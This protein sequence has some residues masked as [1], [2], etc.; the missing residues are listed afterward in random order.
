MEK[1]LQEIVD[2]LGNNI[3]NIEE[4]AQDP[5]EY[6]KALEELYELI[7]KGFEVKEYRTAPI[8]F[9]LF[10]RE[11]EDIHVLEFRHFITNMMFWEPLVVLDVYE[12]MD[13]SHIVNCNELS[14][15]VIK[16]YI[17][18]KIILP[19]RT[20]VGNR[21]LN[22][23]IHD[24]IYTLSR[25][26]KD[27]NII[28]G[29]S[30][31]VETF[32]DVA[33]KNPRFNEII[34]TQ[35][36]ENTQPH[37]IE[38]TLDRL[39]KEQI[40][41]L[42]TEDNFLKPILLSKTGIKDKQLSEFAI[43]G[44]LKPDIE[45]NT[46]PVPINSNFIVGGLKNI[47]NYY[48]DSLGGR[49]SA[50]MNATVMGS[51]G[52]FARMMMMLGTT[53]MMDKDNDDCGSV[54]PIKFTIKTK[55]HLKRLKGR[56]YRPLT[57]RKYDV[58]RGDEKHLIGTSVLVRSPITCASENGICKK[59]Y[60]QLHYTNDDIYSIGG[61]AG[62]KITEPLSQ[63]ILSSK[64]LLTT[65]SQRV[66]FN[67]N[68]YNYFEMG[69]N[70]IIVDST[71][72]T[73]MTAHA[74][75]ILK[76]NIQTIVEFD[77]SEFNSYVKLFHVVNTLTGEMQEIHEKNMVDLYI[78]PELKTAMAKYDE[79]SAEAYTIP[80]D[81][82]SED[83]KLFVVEIENNELTRPLYSLMHLLN[84]DGNDGCDTPEEMAE[85]MLDLLIESKIFSDSVHG[86]ILIRPLIRRASDILKHPDFKSYDAIKDYQ[87]L[88]VSQSL[89]KHPSVLISLSFQ[90]LQ[91]QLV[92]PLTF[93]KT[94]KSF[95]D[96]FYRN[97]P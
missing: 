57:H 22:K 72:E 35:I 18:E 26:S 16:D 95:I 76:E 52:H 93:R 42:K 67:E 73:D 53:V 12:N 51:S 64:H 40:E 71:S 45:G 55:E 80:L 13:T 37:D 65:R 90:N 17:D 27:F 70:E 6:R 59:C 89:E 25:V 94:E 68:F 9:R 83:D 33:K 66:E 78:S 50:I 5:K 77:E 82:F 4:L 49:K 87:I 36:D 97:R 61:Y 34:R 85:R 84:R 86:E 20:R 23:T 60:G 81:S 96:S 44:G 29:L 2:K 3:I 31:N 88:T 8:Y 14:S 74:L 47:T 10:D 58:I 39:M 24:M 7:K 69:A 54:H 15:G 11:G 1:H 91:R 56:N 38:S 63:S 46:I 79:A 62:A 75:V 48:I 32:M 21:K 92:S 28:L 30:M 41:I 43:N 19:Y